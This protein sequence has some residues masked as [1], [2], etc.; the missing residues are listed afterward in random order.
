MVKEENTLFDKVRIIIGM[1]IG[2]LSYTGWIVGSFFFIFGS[3]FTRSI[4]LILLVY[5]YFF[6]KRSILYMEF[7]RWLTPF[8]YFDKYELVIEEPLK[9]GKSLFCY[10]PHGIAG[11]GMSMSAAFSNIIYDSFSCVSRGMILIPFS[12]IFARWMGLVGVDNKNFKEFMKEGKNIKFLPGGFEEATLTHCE[13]ERIFVK[14][15]KGFIK[16]SLQFGY[17]LYPIY[18][19]NENKVYNTINILEGFRLWLNK[20]KIPGT[21]FYGKYGWLPRTDLELITVIGKGIELPVIENPSNEQ[22]D[23][24]HSLYIE[25]LQEVFNKHKEKYGFN[26]ELEIH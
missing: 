2:L 8:R 10:H 15:R 12:G 21:L 24:Y 26:G 25:K 16:Y 4:L 19:F 5:Q 7:L 3:S 17:T 23:Y 22:I 6:A 9:E 20:L 18:T 1:N 11:F 14:D 13:K